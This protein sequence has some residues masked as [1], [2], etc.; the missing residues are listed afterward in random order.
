MV[1]NTYY[2]KRNEKDFANI[3]E[4][5][6]RV[7]E[8]H[9]LDKRSVLRMRLLAEE[10]IC[11]L[12]HLLK[13]GKGKFWIENVGKRSE[14]HLGVMIDKT[15]EYDVDR[16]LSISGDGKNAASKGIVGRLVVWLESI[17]GNNNSVSEDPYGVW[18]RGLADYDEETIW[19]LK[20]YRDAFESEE[21]KRSY[22]E[23]WDELEKSILANL[24]DN[25]TVGVAMGKIEIVIEKS[26]K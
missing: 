10:L 2:L 21:V 15:G 24:A 16:I 5:A 19:S 23:D 17:V 12:P 20:N 13:Y 26:F 18:S 14:L 4:E 1:S 3:P 11:M 6:Q 22:S 9:N 25:V 7:A 8:Y